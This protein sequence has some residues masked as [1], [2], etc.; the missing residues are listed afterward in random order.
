MSG[1]SRNLTMDLAPAHS[2]RTKPET[3][4]VNAADVAWMTAGV[5]VA[6]ACLRRRRVRTPDTEEKKNRR[7]MREIEQWRNG[8]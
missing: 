7:I 8:K 1:Q 6:L 4:I 5:L 2:N 3:I